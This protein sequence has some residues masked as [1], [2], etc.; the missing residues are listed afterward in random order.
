M[1]AQF[2]GPN[3]A[4]YQRPDYLEQVTLQTI[5]VVSGITELQAPGDNKKGLRAIALVEQIDGVLRA[6]GTTKDVAGRDMVKFLSSV[7]DDLGSLTDTRLQDDMWPQHV[8]GLT[9]KATAPAEAIFK[10]HFQGQRSEV[11]A[12]HPAAH[13]PSAMHQRFVARNAM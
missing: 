12:Y 8:Q 4:C 3:Y 13:V 10:R 2:T 5:G 6:H 9:R 1:I 11:S 7:R